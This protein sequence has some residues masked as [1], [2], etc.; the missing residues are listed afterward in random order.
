MWSTAILL[1]PAPKLAFKGK[2]FREQFLPA[3]IRRRIYWSL[4]TWT[5]ISPS[6]QRLAGWVGR[7]RFEK[8]PFCYLLDLACVGSHSV[9]G[10]LLLSLL[11]NC[12][13]FTPSLCPSDVR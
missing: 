12:S 4:G 10:D 5:P 13:I 2:I 8:T 1:G 9:W 3:D 11:A 6:A 7:L